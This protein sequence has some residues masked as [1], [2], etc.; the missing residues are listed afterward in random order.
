MLIKS[1]FIIVVFVSSFGLW[2]LC[3]Q[4]SRYPRG[5]YYNACWLSN[6]LYVSVG[7]RWKSLERCVSNK[8]I[9]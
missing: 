3:F 8:W 2:L 6:R 7:L 4:R 1:V 9:I 5:A